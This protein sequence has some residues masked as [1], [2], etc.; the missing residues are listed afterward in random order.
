[1]RPPAALI[2]DR[3]DR[4]VLALDQIELG[5]QAEPLGGKRHRARVD[6]ILLA[7]LLGL[8]QRPRSAVDPAMHPTTLDGV[9]RIRPFPLHPFEVRQP[10]TI[11]KLVD[12][13][14]RQVWLIWEQRWRR[15]RELRLVHGNPLAGIVRLTAKTCLEHRICKRGVNALTL[16]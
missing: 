2:V 1:V 12:H 11:L 9:G 15:K 4:A 10:R 5:N 8:G 13:S 16:P 6:A 7:D 14:R 3:L